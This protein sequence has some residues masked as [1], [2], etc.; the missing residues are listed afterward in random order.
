ML[1]TWQYHQ[2]DKEMKLWC[3][4][5]A[6][7]RHAVERVSSRQPSSGPAMQTWSPWTTGPDR[8]VTPAVSGA[9]H[10][11]QTVVRPHQADRDRWCRPGEC[12]AERG[13]RVASGAA[14]CSG[15]ERAAVWS[16]RPASRGH[17]E[18]YAERLDAKKVQPENDQKAARSPWSH[19]RACE[20]RSGDTAASISGARSSGSSG[21]AAADAAEPPVTHLQATR[22]GGPLTGGLRQTPRAC[23]QLSACGFLLRAA[24]SARHPEQK[25]SSGARRTGAGRLPATDL[26]LNRG[27]MYSTVDLID[28]G[29]Q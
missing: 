9:Q 10:C 14:A 16:Q 1:W 2:M 24:G 25:S 4:E 18:R 7:R 26:Y 8:H 15:V 3:G 17:A 5:T 28:K 11:R 29:P 6:G 21:G 27:Q 20:V 23:G 22:H 12:A 13:E 19:A